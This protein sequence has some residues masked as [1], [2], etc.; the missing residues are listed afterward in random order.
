[1]ALSKAYTFLPEEYHFSIMCKALAHPAR[2][3][4]IRNIAFKR[5]ANY[6]D[7]SDDIP[8]SRPSILQ[9]LR[10]LREMNIVLCEDKWPK[11]IYR[12][13]YDLP[14]TAI[15]LIDLAMRYDRKQNLDFAK[16][17]TSVERRP[18]VLAE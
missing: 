17:I 8:L 16:E 14:N 9:H 18:G 2:L 12:I 7:A 11:A 10:F 4:L 3:K 5:E 13:N 15:G 1:M 6:L